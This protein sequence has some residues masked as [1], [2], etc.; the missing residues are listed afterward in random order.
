MSLFTSIKVA[1]AATFTTLALAGSAMAAGGNFTVTTDSI[2]GKIKEGPSAVL[3]SGGKSILVY[4]RGMDDAMWENAYSRDKK[5]WR[6]WEKVGGVLNSSP[7]CTVRFFST[8]DCFVLTT[9]GQVS[10]IS[11][12]NG[13]WSDWDGLGG[14]VHGAPFAATNGEDHILL[15]VWNQ[16]GG[17]SIKPYVENFGGWKDGQDVGGNITTSPSCVMIG[18]F[19]KCFAAGTDGK[20]WMYSTAGFTTGWKGIGGETSFRVSVVPVTG[21]GNMHV[22]MLNNEGHLVRSLLNAKTGLGPWEDVVPLQTSGPSCVKI[23]NT[24]PNTP[25]EQCFTRAPD[26][27]VQSTIITPN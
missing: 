8:V 22:Y 26:G 14:P 18:N 19:Y 21:F 9:G 6:G 13:K 23:G 5:T 10:H 4:A 15:T 12:V 16:R 7:S 25:I 24:V 27:S 1:V 11:K 17:L 20:L 3:M 2:G